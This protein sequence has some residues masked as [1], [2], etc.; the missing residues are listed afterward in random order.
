VTQISGVPLALDGD[1]LRYDG[2]QALKE[3]GSTELAVRTLGRRL[4]LSGEDIRHDLELGNVQRF[5]ETKVYT[6]VFALADRLTGKPIARAVL[7]Q[8]Q[9][10]SPKITR[11]LTTDW[12]ANRVE[13]RYRT[14]L[15]RYANSG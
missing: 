9:L 12:F 11:K 13:G 3:A 14:C 4:D 1:V 15:T 10:Q 7:P 6:R 2:E 5:E 8:I